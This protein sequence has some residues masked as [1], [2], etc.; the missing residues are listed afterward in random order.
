M[1]SL[2]VTCNGVNYASVAALAD[3]FGERADRLVQRLGLGW[4]PEEAVGIVPRKRPLNKRH[5]ITHL[6][7]TYDSLVAACLTLGLEPGTV[8]ARVRNGYSVT[9][10]L[11][12]NLKPRIG[13]T[14]KPIEF[15]GETYAS[16]HELCLKH[17][18][19]W[20]NVQRRI[21]RGWTIEQALLIEPAPPRFRNHEGHARDHKWKEV[22]INEGQIEPVPDIGGFKLYVVTNTVNGKQYVGLTM[23]SLEQRL[24]QHFSAARR[25]RKSAFTNAL[26]KYGEPAFTVSLIRSDAKSYA[27]LQLQEVEEIQRRDCI[28]KG[29]NTAKG[30]AIGTSKEITIAGKVFPSLAAA[31]DAYAIDSTVFVLRLSRLKWSAE[32]AAGLVERDWEGKAQPVTIG[33]VEHQSLYSAA[34]SFGVNYKLV[35]NRVQARGWTLEQ[36][37]GLSPAPD[38]RKYAGE[39][40][41]VFGNRYGSIGEAARALGVNVE[42][43]RKRMREGISPEEAY[44]RAR[45]KTHI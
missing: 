15:R 6:G 41:E 17:N 9:D 28:R 23:T 29:Y 10:A 1:P 11:A 18:Q 21:S 31:A 42:S 35:H 25:G 16:R 2:P 7:V 34:M 26:R 27:A 19:R 40:V 4:T 3:H 5:Q 22:R 8:G 13:H 43:F 32:E 30:G 20:G 14:A 36:A 45:K 38:S 12:G 33:G 44:E 24:K 37:V 39:A